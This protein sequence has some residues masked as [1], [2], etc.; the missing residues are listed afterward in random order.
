V[1]RTPDEIVRTNVRFSLQPVDRPPSEAELLRIFEHMHSD[2]L[3]VFSTD[4][5]HPHFSGVEAMP[6]GLP[7]ALA[8]KI[9]VENPLATY[10]RL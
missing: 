7:P 4:Y 3:L 8:H 2:E 9:A 10:S 5:P 6:D 1:D